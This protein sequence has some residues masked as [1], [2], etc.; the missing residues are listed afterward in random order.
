MNSRFIK[1][2]AM[3]GLVFSLSACMKN[4]KYEWGNYNQDL[5]DYYYDGDLNEFAQSL[6]KNLTKAEEKGSVPPGLYAEYGYILLQQGDANKAILYFQKEKN[7]WPESA[8]LMEKVITRLSPKQSA[9][10][11][12]L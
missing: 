10:A 1:I 11:D 7:A 8:Y 9:Q 6:E 3:I 12:T 5:L 2:T 4:T